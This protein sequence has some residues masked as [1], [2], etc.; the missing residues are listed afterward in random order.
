VARAATLREGDAT[1][2]IAIPAVVVAALVT[3]QGLAGR[4]RLVAYG[5]LVGPTACATC[6][7]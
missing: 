2:G 6:A 5:A 4:E 1:V 7:G 3:P